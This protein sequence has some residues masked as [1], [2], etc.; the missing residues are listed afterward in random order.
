MQLLKLL[1][2]SEASSPSFKILFSILYSTSIFL[3]RLN[4]DWLDDKPAGMVVVGWHGGLIIGGAGI[5]GASGHG[6]GLAG[7]SGFAG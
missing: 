3:L 7:G 1:Y 6:S 2:A 4:V 5:G